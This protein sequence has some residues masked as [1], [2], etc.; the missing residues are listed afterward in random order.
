MEAQDLVRMEDRLMT[1]FSDEKF[2]YSSG[3]T[4]N[5]MQTI[6]KTELQNL[7]LLCFTLKV[8]VYCYY[9][10]ACDETVCRILV[11]NPLPWGF[12]PCRMVRVTERCIS[13]WLV[14]IMA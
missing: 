7:Y 13:C 12:L 8:L 10:T 5:Q 2:L 9:D 6:E 3:I 11:D 14:M 4:R 1:N